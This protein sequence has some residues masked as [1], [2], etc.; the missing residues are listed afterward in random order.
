MGRFFKGFRKAVKSNEEMAILIAT[1]ALA[2]YLYGREEDAKVI[3][4]GL[5]DALEVL[6]DP[7]VTTEDKIHELVSDAINKVLTDAPLYVKVA[8][9]NTM[10]TIVSLVSEKLGGIDEDKILD[11]DERKAWKHVLEEM[12]EICDM[13]IEERERRKKKTK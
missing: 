2:I 10:R 7:E 1:D 13:A 5:Q 4:E 11:P 3:K 12:I 6:D 9:R 8:A